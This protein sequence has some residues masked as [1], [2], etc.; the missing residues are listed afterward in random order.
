MH[1]QEE[2][3]LQAASTFIVLNKELMSLFIGISKLKVGNNKLRSLTIE[4]GN[5]RIR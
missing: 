4:E 2:N 5:I 1:F 3:V